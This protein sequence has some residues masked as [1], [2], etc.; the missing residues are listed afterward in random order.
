MEKCKVFKTEG[1]LNKHNT[2]LRC[3]TVRYLAFY[4]CLDPGNQSANDSGK[5][6]TKG[7][8]DANQNLVLPKWKSAQ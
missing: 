5:N 6:T 1:D 2:Y 7:N 3:R 4:G 8:K